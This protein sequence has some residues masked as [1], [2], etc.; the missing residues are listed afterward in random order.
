MK[1]D[2]GISWNVWVFHSLS[3]RAIITRYG[4][5][6]ML[7]FGAMMEDDEGI[8]QWYEARCQ[9]PCLTSSRVSAVVMQICEH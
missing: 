2:M 9:G 6:G 3:S 8:C 1:I 4:G 5:H 7:A